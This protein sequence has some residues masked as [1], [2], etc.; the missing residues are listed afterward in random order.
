[1]RYAVP[2][3]NLLLLLSPDAV[4]FVEEIQKWTFGLLE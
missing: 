1:M 4:I 3:E 2:I